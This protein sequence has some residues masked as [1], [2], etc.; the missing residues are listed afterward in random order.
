MRA[1]RGVRRTGVT[2]PA[3]L[4][5][6]LSIAAYSPVLGPAGGVGAVAL[7]VTSWFAQKRAGSPSPVSHF[8][9][10]VDKALSTSPWQRVKGALGAIRPG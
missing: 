6:A 1:G 3:S 8:L 4:A 10:S 2:A 9:L 5:A 7:G